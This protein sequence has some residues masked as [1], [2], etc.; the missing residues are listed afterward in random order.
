MA[1]NCIDN[2]VVLGGDPAVRHLRRRDDTVILDAVV[3]EGARHG[4]AWA[5]PVR[6]PHP[7][8]PGL[9]GEALHPPVGLEVD[10]ELHGGEAGAATVVGGG[11][12][13]DGARVADVG[14]DEEVAVLD[15]GQR[16]AAAVDGVEA[17]A[18][19]ELGVDGGAGGQ[20]GLAPQVGPALAEPLLAAVD[21]RRQRHGLPPPP[22]QRRRQRLPHRLRHVV[23]PLPVPVEDAAQHAPLLAPESLTTHKTN[24]LWFRIQL[25]NLIFTCF[26]CQILYSLYFIVQVLFICF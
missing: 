22:E 24:L 17:A 21:E 6:P 18:G 1:A 12:G 15:E 16:G 14:D 23:A 10:G 13:Q 19:A 26:F 2:E 9:V 4:E 11:G 8:H 5:L 25:K 3:A 7:V 20:V